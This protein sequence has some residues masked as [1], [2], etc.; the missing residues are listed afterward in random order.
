MNS[1]MIA[2][3][4]IGRPNGLMGHIGTNG[5]R[6]G[7]QCKNGSVMYW[8]VMNRL[9]R[10]NRQPNGLLVFGVSRSYVDVH[11]PKANS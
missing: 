3:W 10:E 1:R 4:G 2:I 8:Q 9:S 11:E 7:I 6:D 5:L